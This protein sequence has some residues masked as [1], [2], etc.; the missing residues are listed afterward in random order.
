MSQEPLT[1]TPSSHTTH[2]ARS[3]AMSQELAAP[4]PSSPHAAQG[5]HSPDSVWPRAFPASHAFGTPF[6]PSASVSGV[7]AP[8][9]FGLGPVFPP[10][11]Q[12]PT[13]MPTPTPAVVA[14]STPVAPPTSPQ[15][16]PAAVPSPSASSRAPASA[17]QAP[18]RARARAP[19]AKKGQEPTEDTYSWSEAAT[20]AM[21]RLRCVDLVNQFD[22]SSGVSS[23]VAWNKV[24]D[25]MASELK[26]LKAP[27]GIQARAKWY[28]L[29][30]AVKVCDERRSTIFIR[31]DLHRK[32]RLCRSTRTR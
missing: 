12:L 23:A 22:P 31:L 7:G 30:G 24:G 3:P 2:R 29:L 1:P 16:V 18:S 27:T 9:P 5:I 15:P 25:A 6:A 20:K 14:P 10:F 32:D 26:E 13:V 19:R 28:N 4:S 8:I 21:V 11:I 17:P